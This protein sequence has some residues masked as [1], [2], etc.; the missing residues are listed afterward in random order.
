MSFWSLIDS[1]L[2]WE[3]ERAFFLLREKREIIFQRISWTFLRIQEIL[4]GIARGGE[5]AV[6]LNHDSANRITSTWTVGAPLH[7]E[8]LSYMMLA[9]MWFLTP[10]FSFNI[11]YWWFILKFVDFTNLCWRHIWKPPF[12]NY[13]SS[14][15]ALDRP[16]DHPLKTWISALLC[17]QFPAELARH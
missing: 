13:A 11:I 17:M 1:A 15:P 9:I 6:F 16:S 12:P 3:G 5:R 7:P 8:G 4:M 2:C 14:Q 10:S